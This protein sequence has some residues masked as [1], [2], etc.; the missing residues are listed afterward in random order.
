MHFSLRLFVFGEY[1]GLFRGHGFSFPM[2]WWELQPTRLRQFVVLT[3]FRDLPAPEDLQ[4]TTELLVFLWVFV[5]QSSVVIILPFYIEHVQGWEC[6]SRKGIFI[7]HLH[8]MWGWSVHTYIYI[9]KTIGSTKVHSFKRTLKPYKLYKQTHCDAS[10]SVFL[11]TLQCFLSLSLSLSLSL[12]L[13]H[14]HTHTHTHIHTCMHACM[15]TWT[16]AHMDACMHIHI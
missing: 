15:R 2:F 7:K 16:H 12:F 10:F 8:L 4:A 9:Y 13:S 11:I 6:V 5:L 14:T 1:K 3:F